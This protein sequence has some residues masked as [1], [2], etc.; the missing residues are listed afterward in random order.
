[1]NI[2]LE[3]LLLSGLAVFLFKFNF[4]YYAVKK[5]WTK[6]T[7]FD[8]NIFETFGICEP[9]SMSDCEWLNLAK[10]LTFQNPSERF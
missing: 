9:S 8:R 10:F 2:W 4:Y 5:S 6:I 7:I 1:M 3:E